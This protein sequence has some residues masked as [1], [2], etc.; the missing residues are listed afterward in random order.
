MALDGNDD[1]DNTIAELITEVKRV[2]FF[3]IKLAL[4]IK[5]AWI[6]G[7]DIQGYSEKEK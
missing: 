3:Y 4:T 6:C 2:P 7:Y 5:L 1:R